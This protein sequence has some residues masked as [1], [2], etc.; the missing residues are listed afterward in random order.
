MSQKKKSY[1]D[2]TSKSLLISPEQALFLLRQRKLK[3]MTKKLRE[4]CEKKIAKFC[5][6]PLDVPIDG[7]L[8]EAVD[9]VEKLLVGMNWKV[10]RHSELEGQKPIIRLAMR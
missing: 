7:Y 9:A 10:T 6:P 2:K 3:R 1:K 5:G 4:A 8:P